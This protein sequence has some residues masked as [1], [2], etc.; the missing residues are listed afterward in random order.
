MADPV[1]RGE[2]LTLRDGGATDLA[3]VSFSLE[4][5]ALTALVGPDDHDKDALAAVLRG[6]RRPDVGTLRFRG[7]PIT[8][9][10][11]AARTRL[12]LVWT[13]RPAVPFATGSPIEAVALAARRPGD[14]RE[15][16]RRRPPPAT[17]TAAREILTFVGLESEAEARPD[18]LGAD[19]RVRLELARALAADPHLLVVD[20]LTDELDDAHARA[21]LIDR[22]RAIA[23]SGPGVLWIEDDV[24]LALEH[25]DQVVTLEHGR[26]L[27][28]GTL[29]ASGGAE[30]FEAAFLGRVR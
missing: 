17:A 6:E 22:L 1:L 19:D 28:P 11:G 21:D 15:P 16:F 30:A 8:R 18:H 2:G 14:W 29:A 27:T 3:S 25:A 13:R 9:L 12:G 7:R 10:G 4:A 20:R 26:I 5:G 23:R 24:A